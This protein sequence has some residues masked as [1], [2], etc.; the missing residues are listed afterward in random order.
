MH[1]EIN[2]DEDCKNCKKSLKYFNS[3]LKQHKKCYANMNMVNYTLLNGI[4]LSPDYNCMGHLTHFHIEK[5]D[6]EFL[7]K[8]AKRIKSQEEESKKIKE[9]K[10]KK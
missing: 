7:E 6:S 2:I 3:L 1:I 9:L 8:L 10:L 5:A 4:Y